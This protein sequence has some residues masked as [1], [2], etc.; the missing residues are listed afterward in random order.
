MEVD[1]LPFGDVTDGDFDYHAAKLAMQGMVDLWR[2]DSV[3]AKKSVELLSRFKQET[4]EASAALCEQLRIILE[5]Q[6]SQQLQGN[7]KTGKRLNMRKVISF[8]ASHYRNDK[9]WL[10]RTLPSKR[11]YKILLA[12]DD[13]LSMH[14]QSCGFF[15]LE[16]MVTLTDAPAPAGRRQGRR[17]SHPRPARPP[18]E[19]RVP[20]VGRAHC[21]RPEPVHLPA[22]GEGVARLRDG[23]LPQGLQPDA[24][25]AEQRVAVVGRNQLP[26]R[27]HPL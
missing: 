9:I 4:C 23:Q 7:F 8:I 10:R 1:H 2:S 12:I 14:E 3:E 19:L 21:L 13:S 27:D 18:P 6:L 25:R 11:D 24:R 20:A 5:P 17:E 16:A 26:V 15:S 22:L